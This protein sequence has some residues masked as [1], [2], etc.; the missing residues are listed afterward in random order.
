MPKEQ[1]QRQPALAV[2]MSSRHQRRAK[3]YKPKLPLVYAP[4]PTPP[5]PPLP[6]EQEQEQE[7]VLHPSPNIPVTLVVEN[8]DQVATWADYMDDLQFVAAIALY[9]KWAMEQLLSGYHHKQS[10]KSNSH[11]P[12][13]D[14]LSVTD[15]ISGAEWVL[16]LADRQHLTGKLDA[17]HMNV[18]YPGYTV[19]P[20]T[21]LHELA[22]QVNVQGIGSFP[23]LLP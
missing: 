6:R 7:P 3:P 20:T 19:P 5:S 8:T 16:R 23:G 15:L 9:T 12:A 14:L 2:G 21:R 17:R 13:T 22:I 10:W 4:A 1:R 11:H 18:R